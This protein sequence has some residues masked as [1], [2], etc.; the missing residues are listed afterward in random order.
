MIAAAL[1]LPSVA[2]S[3]THVG[4]SLETIAEILNWGTWIAFAIELVV[5]VILVPDRKKY[6][7]HHPVELIVVFLTPPG[8]ARRAPEPARNWLLR[9]L[10]LL[11]LAKVSRQASPI[12]AFSMR[13]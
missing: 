1:T 5:M 7:V 8:P 2:L 10:R 6:L 9:L 12:R 13:P 4:G 11:K 3:E